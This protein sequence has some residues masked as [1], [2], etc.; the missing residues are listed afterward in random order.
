MDIKKPVGRTF[1][2]LR[3]GFS[4]PNVADAPKLV[5]GR[6]GLADSLWKDLS[7]GS[8]RLLAER[9]MGKTWLL[10]LALARK[11]KWAAP[12]FFDAQQ[13][14]DACDFVLRLNRQLHAEGLVHDSWWGKAQEWFQRLM[15]TLG[16]KKLGPVE[17]PA[18]LMTWSGFLTQTCQHVIEQRPD[19][20][21]VLIFDELPL[22][23]DKLITAQ[24][25]RDAVTFLDTLR[26]L[27]QNQPA[28]R[29]VF[30]GSLGLH[31]VLKKLEVTGYTGRPVN[32]MHP[33][34]VPPLADDIATELA[35]GLITGEGVACKEIPAC[36][37]S[38]A[39]ISAGCPFYI[40]KS[41]KWMKD[42]NDKPWIPKSVQGIVEAAANA[43]ADP[44]EFRYY[45][46]RLTQHYPEDTG[47][48]ERARVTLDIL[49]REARG[50][51][52]DQVLNHVRHHPK[53]LTLDPESLL[54]VLRVLQEDHYLIEKDQQ[55]SFKLEVIRQGWFHT[56]GRHNL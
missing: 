5:V 11:P 45:D 24:R 29:M 15:V 55:W 14:E 6:D 44:F 20:K 13:A 41:V 38:V 16:G 28:L 48:V 33:F 23:L 34:D 31:I 26:Y 50:L 37:R 22:F 10:K 3:L 51:P 32:D 9:R 46:G 30:C 12:L 19:Q 49:S 39:R 54:E 53:T 8:L 43:A 42:H 36:A 2:P 4:T 47:L 17:V 52:F 40:Q 1:K 35:G 27:R 25:P 18:N 21:V 7:Q 56:R